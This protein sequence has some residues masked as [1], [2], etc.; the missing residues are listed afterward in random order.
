MCTQVKSCVFLALCSLCLLGTLA[1]LA[2]TWVPFSQECQEQAPHRPYKI[3]S[4]STN[5]IYM[6][7]FASENFIARLI[8]TAVVALAWIIMMIGICIQNNCVQ[9]TV[10]MENEFSFIFFKN[11]VF[12]MV[13]C[14][15]SIVVAALDWKSVVAA[16]VWCYQGLNGLSN[17]PKEYSCDMAVFYVA[18]V[19]DSIIAICLLVFV[20]V[21]Y[22]ATCCC[23]KTK[24]SKE[25]GQRLIS[26]SA[27]EKQSS[28]T[29]SSSI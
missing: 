29:T 14:A 20:V 6:C 23:C 22:L 13:C 12:L 27:R 25:E 7:G 18:P 1:L 2:F 11:T 26:A 19:A 8:M 28:V 9:I 24:E 4:L 10:C 3:N 5:K 21:Y 15:G 16:T 17:K